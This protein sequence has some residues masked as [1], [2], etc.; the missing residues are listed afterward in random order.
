[1]RD[2]RYRYHARLKPFRAPAPSVEQL[3][4]KHLSIGWHLSRS[5]DNPDGPPR[6]M[7]LVDCNDACLAIFGM[8]REDILGQTHRE[9]WPYADPFWLECHL[10]VARTGQP[11]HFERGSIFQQRYWDCQMYSPAPGLVAVF[12]REI[13]AQVSADHAIRALNRALGERAMEL[14]GTIQDL[15]AFTQTVAH[16]LYA[17]IRHIGGFAGM[18]ERRLGSSLDPQGQHYL[19]TIRRSTETMGLLM[20]RLLE[21]ARSGRAPLRRQE[22]A[23]GDLVAR[24]WDDLAPERE[25]RC[26]QWQLDPLPHASG[27]PVLLLTVLTNLLGNALKFTRPRA[28]AHL[29]VGGA[30]TREDVVLFVRDNG[31]GF[32]PAEA[33]R[34]FQVFQRLHP[35]AGIRGTGLGLATVQRI[36]QRHGGRVWAEGAVGAGATFFLALPRDTGTPEAEARGGTGPPAG[37]G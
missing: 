9:I 7:R 25:D 4:L 23:L 15:E 14:E 34:L 5:V 10:Q 24:A 36:V 30:E 13:G 17:P 32:D 6:E 27:D 18:L 21:L 8:R 1:M 3:V 31:L 11:L 12:F 28:E 37:N 33:H 20:D 26:I 16:D 2:L 19:D 35:D 22:M 29:H